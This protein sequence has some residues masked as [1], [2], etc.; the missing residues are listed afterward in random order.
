MKSR[1]PKWGSSLALLA[2]ASLSVQGLQAE[3]VNRGADAGRNY[4]TQTG[5]SG[6]LL[7]PPSYDE[8]L[9]AGKPVLT[10]KDIYHPGWIDLNKNGR[11]DVYEDA[12]QPVERRLDDLLA[13]MTVEEMTA[14][15][16]TLY[17][18]TRVCKDYLPT[19]QWKNEHW[20][21]GVGNIDEHLTGFFYYNRTNLPG[22]NYLWPASK[23]TWALNE[24]QRFFVEDTRLGVP[25]EFTDEGI[26]GVEHFK[27]T[28]F[29]TQL[30]LGQTWD[31]ALIHRVGEITAKEGSALGF[32][33]VYAPILDVMRDPRWGRCE[34]SYGEDPFLVS[35]LAIQ[36]VT[37]MQ[38]HGVASTL[39]HFCIYAD[40][41]GA[42]EGFSRVDPQCGPREA[43]SIHL[44]PFERVIR[45]A[46][47]LSVMSSYND[48]DG[49]PIEGSPYY[50][51]DVLRKRMGFKGYVV[52][53]SDAVEYLSAKHR[54]AADFKDAVR[55][56]V[57]SG[58]NIR[59]TFSAP[60]T[61]T[62]PLRELVREG[63]I[64]KSV[65]MARVRDI[66]RVKLWEGTF[67]APY[68]PLKRADE[69]VLNP[70]HVA[71]AL[72]AA[73]ES[74]VLLKNENGLLPL[75]A[76]RMHRI[77]VVGPNAD[78]RNYA[79]GHYGPL[80]SP[81]TTVR[82][83]LEA[84]FKGR[85]EVLYAK[86][87]AFLDEHWPDTEVMWQPPTAKEQQEI[88]AAAALA[89]QADVVIAV[90][91]DTPRGNPNIQGTSGENCSRT[92]IALTG[93]QDDLIRALAATGKPVVLV[94]ISGR[95]TALNWANKVCPAILQA[96]FPGMEGGTAI[97]EALFGEYNPG[98]KLTCTFPK[99]AGQLQLNFPAKPAA[100]SEAGG[101]AV[102][103]LLWPFG[104]GLSYARFEYANLAITPK[105][106]R[107]DGRITV[108]FEVTNRGARAGDEV[109][110]MYVRQC[111][112]SVTTYEQNLRGF[113]RIHLQPG[114]TKTVTFELEPDYL[115]IWNL[116][117]KRVVE[118]GKFEVQIGA[119]SKDIRLKGG[120][121][122]VN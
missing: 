62:K 97:V 65:L 73:R 111:V 85:A 95:P 68:R 17:G 67:D 53:D 18:Y 116:A 14:Q 51:T 92:G 78:D 74:L 114:E 109:P 37:G 16:A 93:R 64:P 47:P 45:T 58:L 72:Q 69:C 90:V 70:A 61:F 32:N 2:A 11:K 121:A 44:W 56:S 31:R 66:L 103:G 13:Q 87:C 82:E 19:V 102:K 117:M 3:K 8:C 99:T 108:R 49:V 23:H 43:E 104:H 89:Q 36:M 5:G 12:A 38:T 115:A 77:A 20:K 75:D 39:K 25:A 41:K 91:G 118:P 7:Y 113:E 22:V 27:A 54:T 84:K 105:E 6:E 42:R 76:A 63:A 112:S 21:D 29:P 98:G 30:G 1:I 101:V 52:S 4:G 119:S 80:C 100:S 26:R 50:L 107:A 48:Y 106:R 94:N 57:L 40:N 35:E 110:Q 122:I 79:Q 28:D 55:Q 60:E 10:R 15:M 86:G 24:V 46:Q 81:V 59:T 33:N 9:A 88:D 120:F 71:V 34:E 83:A 96:F